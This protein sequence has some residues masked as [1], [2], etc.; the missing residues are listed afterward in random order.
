MVAHPEPD[1]NTAVGSG[2]IAAGSTPGPRAG[3]GSSRA[4]TRAGLAIPGARAA[5][6]SVLDLAH[7]RQPTVDDVFVSILG[8]LEG[9]VDRHR[10][11]ESALGDQHFVVLDVVAAL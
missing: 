5:Q 9:L 7:E 4:G 10:L 2:P 8:V 1:P 6:R 11:R 3:N